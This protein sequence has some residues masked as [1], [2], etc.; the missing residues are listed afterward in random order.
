MNIYF[1]RPEIA[2][3]LEAADELRRDAL[4]A[5]IAAL[6][7]LVDV[8][9]LRGGRHGADFYARVPSA[10]MHETTQRMVDLEFDIAD[11]YG[12]RF[13]TFAIATASECPP[14]DTP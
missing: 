7:G 11:R 13:R 8:R 12:V 1:V 10:E 3:E 5:Y 6:A 14:G 2:E 4:A 9:T